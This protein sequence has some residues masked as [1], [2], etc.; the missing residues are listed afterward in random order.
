MKRR[1]P[2]WSRPLP[3]PL[4]IV[5]VMT[6][7]TLAD[8][9][10]LIERYLPSAYCD[11]PHWQAVARDVQAAPAAGGD[12]EEAV[13]SLRFAFMVEGIACRPTRT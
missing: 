9:R 10:L 11:R 4:P 6:L 7:R 5:D 12:V 2:N 8:V 1:R 3:Q 13:L